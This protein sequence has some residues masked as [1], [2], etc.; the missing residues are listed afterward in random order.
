MLNIRGYYARRKMSSI[1]VANTDIIYWPCRS[2]SR[3]KVDGV[4]GVAPWDSYFGQ[5][6]V[7]LSWST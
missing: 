1:Y 7:T 6:Q 5:L 2:S 4:K 3:R